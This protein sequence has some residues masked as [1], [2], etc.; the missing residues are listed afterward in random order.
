MA[1]ERAGEEVVAGS[2]GWMGG[3]MG[4]AAAAP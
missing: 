4:G 1:T 3:W 2:M